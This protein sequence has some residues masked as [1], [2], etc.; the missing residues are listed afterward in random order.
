MEHLR[1]VEFSKRFTYI[2]SFCSPSKALFY[3]PCYLHLFTGIG[4]TWGSFPGCTTNKKRSWN[5]NS[6]LFQSF[7]DTQQNQ[8]YQHVIYRQQSLYRFSEQVLWVL[9][10]V[11]LDN[12]QIIKLRTLPLIPE[13]S[14][15]LACCSSAAPS[16][17]NL[18][19][20]GT[21]VLLRMPLFC[22]F[23]LG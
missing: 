2:T 3:R 10:N 18:R 23:N 12:H 15:Y 6:S 20:L 8:A 11:Q 19:L 17:T 7:I 16:N 9:I 4:V 22:L 1:P 13:V 5:L 14:S 21:T